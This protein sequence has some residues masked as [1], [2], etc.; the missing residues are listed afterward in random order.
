MS[1]FDSLY[2]DLFSSSKKYNA[3]PEI[4]VLAFISFCQSNNILTLLNLFFYA[5]NFNTDYK[6]HHYYIVLQIALYIINYYYYEMRNHGKP[7]LI[8]NNSIK[9]RP[10]ISY[11]YIISSVLLAGITYYILKEF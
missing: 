4:P 2:Y 6:I 10:Y 5:L 8:N 9:V 1:F 11:L 7:I 3:A